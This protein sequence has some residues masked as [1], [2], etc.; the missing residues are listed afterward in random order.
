MHLCIWCTCCRCRF[1]AKKYSEYGGPAECRVWLFGLSRGAYTARAVAG[2]I[3]NCGIL[4]FKNKLTD[5]EAQNA[6]VDRAHEIYIR[7][8]ALQL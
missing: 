8:A 4:D 2:M 3:N 5:V 6:A 7:C 1:I